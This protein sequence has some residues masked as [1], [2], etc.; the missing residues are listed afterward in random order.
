MRAA[1]KLA[2]EAL[3]HA[4][5]LVAPGVTTDQLDAAV[6]DYIITRGGYPSPLRYGGYPKSSCTSVNECICHGM[7]DDRL[8]YLLLLSNAPQL[9][10]CYCEV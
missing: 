3:R 7:P 4:G 9:M 8:V 6:H 5:R 1:G 2:A 10:V